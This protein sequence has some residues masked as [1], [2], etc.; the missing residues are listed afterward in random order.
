MDDPFLA[1]RNIKTNL[2]KKNKSNKNKTNNDPVTD[3]SVGDFNVDSS[4]STLLYFHMGRTG[5]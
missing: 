5:I 3:L 4:R 1:L 2:T